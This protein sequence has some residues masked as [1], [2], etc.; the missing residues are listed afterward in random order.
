MKEKLIRVGCLVW[1][2]VVILLSIGVGWLVNQGL[3]NVH[4]IPTI[5][6][7]ILSGVSG[8]VAL[9]VF[10]AV[11]FLILIATDKDYD[12]ECPRFSGTV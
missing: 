6:N 1:V 5:V 3:S 10:A 7:I 9:F 8:I 2:A 11:S 12:N 4:Q